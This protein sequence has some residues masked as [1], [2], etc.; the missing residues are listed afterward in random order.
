MSALFRQQAV[1]AQKQKLHGDVSLAQPIS[2]YLAVLILLSIIIALVLF[3]SLS[4]YA[5]KETVRG[6]LVPEKGLINT[7]A[8]R[9]GN[10]E[11]PEKFH[12]ADI[13]E[14]Y[15]ISAYRSPHFKLLNNAKHV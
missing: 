1:E 8:N 5:H 4:H 11:D 7:Y 14:K 13:A 2:I 12:S 10:V 3:L 9:N 15:G 6:Y